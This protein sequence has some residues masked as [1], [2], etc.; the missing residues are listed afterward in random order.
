MKIVAILLCM[1]T[2]MLPVA[3]GQTTTNTLTPAQCA[4]L[5]TD[6]INDAALVNARNTRQDQVIADAYSAEATPVY[7]VWKSKLT[8]SQMLYDT[9]VD[10]TFF[11]TSGTG[12]VTR[13]VQEL[14]LFESLFDK[15]TSL[16]NPMN[17]VIR[18][19]F[20]TAMSG[21]T[22]PAPENRTHMLAIAR[23]KANRME[24]LFVDNTT[25]PCTGG[26]GNSP[27]GPCL[28]RYEG[29]VTTQHIACALNLP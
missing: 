8:R 28:M 24:R 13:T 14:M 19:S 16:T 3:Y 9:S 26:T 29:T 10:N 6:I 1:L 15:I 17:S 5:K 2:V 12:F 7:W 27:N 18:A 21:G 4:T 23:Q 20:G 22:S 25:Q 11:S